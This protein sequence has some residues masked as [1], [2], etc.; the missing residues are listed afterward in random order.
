[1]VFICCYDRDHH[2]VDIAASVDL[3]A[4][5]EIADLACNKFPFVEIENSHT[6]EMLWCNWPED[7]RV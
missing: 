6:G 7:V 5:M 4:A 2:A 1:M 3:G